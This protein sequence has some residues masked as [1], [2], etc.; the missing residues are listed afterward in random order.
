MQRGTKI[1][2]VDKFLGINEAADGDT[3]LKM[4]E[5][6]RM[7]NFLITDAYNLTLR[8]G[9]QRADFA[10]ERTPA[11]ILGS[12]AGR[13]GEDDLLVIC[14]F[15]QNADR[16][17]VYRRGT[18]GNRH[19][20]H[21]QTGALGLTSG[22]AA[23]VKIFPFGGKLYVM[24]KGNTVVYKDGTFT[25]EA[26]YVP[27][28]VTGAAPAGGGTT[29]ENLNLLTALR[30]IEYSADGEATAYVLPEEAIGVT[31]ITVDNVAKDVAASGSFDA[32]KH[33]YT[34][35]AAPVKGVANVEFTYTTDAAAAAENRLK[36]LGCPLVEAYN[37]ATDT[38]LFVAG[39][40]TNLCHYTGV[41]QSGEVT[42]LYFP[43][44]NEV[45]VD[46][47]GSP[48]TGL[49]RHY[50]KLLVFKPDGAF[51]ISYEPVT[52]TDGSTIAGFY[53]R[54]A[55][56]EFGNDVLGQIQTVENFPRTFSKNGIYEWRITSSYYKDERYAKRVSDRVMNSLNRADSAGIVTCDD[57][58]D[59]TYYVFLND[60]D[61][62]VLVNRYALAG[63][64][65]LWCIYK[66]ALC[67]SVKNAMVHDGEMVFFTDTDMFFFSQEGL[68]RDAPVTA[69]GNAMAIEAVWESGFQAFGA[70]FQRKYSSEIYISMLPQDKSRM[71]ITAAT[72][73]RSEYMEKE[74]RSELFS[75]SNWD[76]ADFTF[77]LNDTPQIN[78]IRLKV[79]KFVYYKLIFKVN[80][81]GALATVLGYDQKVRFASM[82]K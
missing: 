54:A 10:A 38:R 15:Y 59:K 30:R 25:A 46:M 1:Y 34:F 33:T 51:T 37:G 73:R 79:K 81:D 80:T 64:G 12:W 22:E 42:A 31:A 4:G 32:S 20:A 49:V 48:V 43:A 63:D 11:P 66:S 75:W 6:S 7:E 52:L 55:N 35:T 67:K 5:A 13:V 23:M 82:A 9:I 62:T 17:F 41:P 60:D 21:Q 69:S 70:D 3:E 57:D 56:R 45:A 47:S 44:M 71:T 39:D 50:S 8:P 2:T 19:I 53:L 72:D 65:G 40:G 76:F 14:D 68:S 29:L 27:L 16:L 24:S 61:G 26:P 18:D 58:Y 28:V 77:D 74:V 36:I 78:R